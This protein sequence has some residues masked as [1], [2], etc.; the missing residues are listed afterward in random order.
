MSSLCQGAAVLPIDFG[1]FDEVVVEVIATR[2]HTG[3]PVRGRA[4]ATARSAC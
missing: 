1:L 4:A 3:P 2:G